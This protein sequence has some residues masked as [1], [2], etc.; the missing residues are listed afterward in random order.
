MEV[1]RHII[2]NVAPVHFKLAFFQYELA[3]ETLTPHLQGFILMKKP[4]RVTQLKKI[5]SSKIHFESARGNNQQVWDYCHKEVSRDPFK[6]PSSYYYP[7]YEACHAYSQS[8]KYATKKSNFKA[9]I[10]AEVKGEITKFYNEPNYVRYYSSIKQIAQD[11]KSEA[12]KQSF[13][14]MDFIPLE[15]QE[16]AIKLLDEQTDRQVDLSI[17][18]FLCDPFFHIDFMDF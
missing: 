13:V 5:I 7:S 2:D 11:L 4:V 3:P 8:S 18:E 16:Q 6:Q 10:D 15:W 14:D 12:L 1:L 17:G 9:L